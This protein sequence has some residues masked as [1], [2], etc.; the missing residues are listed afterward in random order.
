MS[1]LL[2]N[3]LIIFV[4]SLTL[5]TLSCLGP[6]GIPIKTYII[7]S[8]FDELYLIFSESESY[9]RSPN[10]TFRLILFFLS[11]L[12]MYITLITPAANS[13]K[14]SNL[15]LKTINFIIF[16]FFLFNLTTNN[17]S[18]IAFLLILAISFFYLLF[19][20]NPENINKYSKIEVLLLLAMLIMFF[21][22][23]LSAVHHD[24][25]LREIDVY[26]RFFLLIPIYLLLRDIKIDYKILFIVINATA[27]IAGLFA[28]Y[29][30]FII[31]EYR[32]MGHTSSATI[33]G[34]VSL[35][36][37]V[38]SY[39]TIPFFRKP[40]YLLALPL[41]AML[42]A[43]IA[44]SL[45]GSRGSLLGLL[46]LLLILFSKKYRDL[47]YLPNFKISILFVIL[48]GA[49]LIQSNNINR[50]VE[51]Y[52]SGYN[53]IVNE[54]KRLN[55]RNP[56]SFLPRLFIWQGS[57][58]IIKENF[59]S[60]VGL[61][62]FNDN[63][64][65]EIEEKRIPMIKNDYDNPTAGLNH[66]H[67][68]YLDI[69]AKTGIGGLTALIFF[70]IVN[71]VFFHQGVCSKLKEVQQLSVFGMATIIMYSSY[72]LTHAVLSHHHSTLFMLMNLILFSSLVTNLK[73]K[74][75]K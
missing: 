8:R 71:M 30:Y 52:N 56:D 5:L 1:H 43:F 29:Q 46:F 60:G 33:Y 68:Q 62:K 41:I 73:N 16:F 17:G 26:T 64:L 75:T 61:D 31:G 14:I 22:S 45:T 25:N 18:N 35:T 3:R 59:Y 23:I 70:L 54:D 42:F 40:K 39:L 67:N 7:S 51:G 13:L 57:Y 74:G 63:L 6:E 9:F 36:L 34:N 2:E 24:S 69:L 21:I 47:L 58:N 55:W 27:I 44:W 20:R 48:F 37:M 12:L 11:F 28:L 65:K 50:I 4:F 38:L 72:M 66:A 10:S 19:I 32:V 53:Y 15:M 49:I